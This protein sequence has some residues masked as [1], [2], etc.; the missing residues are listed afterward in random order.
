MTYAEKL[1]L[2]LDL[3]ARETDPKNIAW[4]D[5]QADKLVQG[6]A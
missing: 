2:I 6:Q 1:Q 5:E 3:R 4:L